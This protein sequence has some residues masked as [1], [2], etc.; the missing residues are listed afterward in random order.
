MG[1]IT[2]IKY[3]HFAYNPGENGVFKT[4]NK[5]ATFYGWSW[6]MTP[7]DDRTTVK[8]MYYCDNAP[9]IKTQPV[10]VTVSEGQE[11]H[12]TVEMESYTKTL[13]YQWGLCEYRVND[14]GVKYLLLPTPGLPGLFDEDLSISSGKDLFSVSGGLTNTL[15]MALGGEYLKQFKEQYKDRMFV[16]IVY[17]S[18]KKTTTYSEPASMTFK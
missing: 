7:G 11:F 14:D 2:G 6:Q 9:K 18:E 13:S 5:N 16:C 10:S 1:E 4:Y 17:D 8:G 15:S 12:F 3:Y